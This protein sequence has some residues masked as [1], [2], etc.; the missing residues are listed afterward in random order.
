MLAEHSNWLSKKS[1]NEDCRRVVVYRTIREHA[2]LTMR[3]WASTMACMAGFM[4]P[5]ALGRHTSRAIRW[6]LLP[7]KSEQEPVSGCAIA[8]IKNST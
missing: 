7:Y 1:W 5:G 8:S 3:S 4:G 2:L 6:K